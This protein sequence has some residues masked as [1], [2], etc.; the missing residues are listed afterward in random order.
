MDEETRQCQNCKKDFIIEPDDF[1]FYEK[2][3]VPAPTWCPDCR[4]QRRLSFMFERSLYKRPCALCGK[5]CVSNFS[6]DKK[7]ITYCSGCW[8]SDKWDVM[9][10][11]KDY[12]PSRPFLEQVR[13][14]AA[15]TPYYTIQQD[16]LTLVNSDYT[17]YVGNAK[18]CYLITI[19]DFCDNVMYSHILANMK[20]SSDCTMLGESEL[21]YGDINL[22]NCYD[23]HFSE[24]SNMCRGCYFVKQC[25]GCN[26]CFGCF[27][28][29]N[30]QYYIFNRPY[31]KEDYR[32]KIKEFQLNTYS[33]LQKAEKEAHAFWLTQPHKYMRDRMN[34]KATGILMIIQSGE[35]MRLA[36]TNAP[37]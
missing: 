14:L 15:E 32:A 22:G 23:T 21:C 29:R 25:V 2:M 10:Y 3:K 28:L 17:A 35:T 24:D 19:A 4:L 27:N 1:A 34:N 20:D 26:D 9:A 31:S 33:G 12:D 7:I 8:W 11:G 30:K 37:Q 36:Y 13:T 18:N 5:S 16:Y 6:P